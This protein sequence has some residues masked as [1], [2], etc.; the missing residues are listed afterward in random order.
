MEDAGDYKCVAHNEVGNATAVA[1]IRV[2]ESP[3]ITL[4]PAT[5]VL[6][7]TEGD[8]VKVV[9]SATGV[10]DPSVR[11]VEDS[12]VATFN[13]ASDADN[14]NEAV[15]EFQRVSMSNGKAYKCMATN[16]AGT[17]ERYVVLDVKPR[18][19]DAPEDSDVDRSP[20]P[21]DRQPPSYNYPQPSY[22]T[23]PQHNYPSQPQPSYPSHSYPSQ[24]QHGYPTQPQHGYPSQPQGGYAVQ[25]L[26]ENIYQSKPG[27]N[28]TLNCDLSKL[29][30]FSLKIP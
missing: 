23:Q 7:V 13:Y 1:T 12:S 24:P 21:Y 18:R 15:L 27:D 11:W 29:L 2:I 25:P 16:E 10:P 22:P 28:V 14:Y 30:N 9:C 8:E 19:G 20:Y 26:P 4:Q 17:D 6:T 5:E 3:V